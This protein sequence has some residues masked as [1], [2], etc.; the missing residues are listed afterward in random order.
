MATAKTGT[1]ARAN[2]ADSGSRGIWSKALLA[3]LLVGG[4]TVWFYGDVIG[5]YAQ[6]GTSY[7][8]KNACSCR[9]LA[10]RELGNCDED[11]L[12]GMQVVFLTEDEEEKS[13]TAT[14][15]LVASNRARF[16][17]GFGCVLDTWES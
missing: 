9:Y 15:P 3:V 13:V 16:R 5:G 17:E 4:A 8:A 14:I 10:G 7:G 6:A 12:P 1:K 2:S 11:F